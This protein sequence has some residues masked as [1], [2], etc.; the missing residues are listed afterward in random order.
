MLSQQQ[1][2]C[3]KGCANKEGHG[4]GG[5]FILLSSAKKILNLLKV[6]KL[7]ERRISGFNKDDILIS[8]VN[9]DDIF[10]NPPREDFNYGMLPQMWRAEHNIL[11]QKFKYYLYI[12]ISDV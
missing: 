2:G 7:R 10:K 5:V 12:P 3:Q 9:N 4:H 1:Q 11:V 8:G 6:R